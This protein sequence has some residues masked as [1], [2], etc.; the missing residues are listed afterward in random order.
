MLLYFHDHVR[1]DFAFPDLPLDPAPLIIVEALYEQKTGYKTQPQS[2]RQRAA[3]CAY[4]GG[5]Q[6]QLAKA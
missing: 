1:H 4:E 5:P 2:K 3:R 6:G